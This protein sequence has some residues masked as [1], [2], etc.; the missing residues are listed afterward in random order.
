MSD[1]GLEDMNQTVFLTGATGAL[2]PILSAE[3]LASNAASRL[4]VLIRPGESSAPVR[5]HQWIQTLES[6]LAGSGSLLPNPRKRVSLVEGD[7][8]ASDLALSEQQHAQLTDE[9]E[10]IIHSAADTNFR[11]KNQAH[12]ETN[13]EGTKRLLDLASRCKRLKKLIY[14]STICAAGIQ[15]GLIRE[16]PIADEPEFANL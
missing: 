16:Q 7:L 10:T 8:C 1:N 12:W 9:A 3:L 2:G 11:A 15:D 6:V 4:R 13:V 14:V 5:F